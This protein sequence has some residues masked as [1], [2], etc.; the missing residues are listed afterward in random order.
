MVIQSEREGKVWWWGWGAKR[1]TRRVVECVTGGGK[2]K[3]RK[4]KNR[5]REKGDSGWM[6]EVGVEWVREFDPHV[7]MIV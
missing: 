3:K 6:G 5:G 7:G 4:K 1:G 2:K